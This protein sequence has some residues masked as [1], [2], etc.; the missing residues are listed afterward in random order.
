MQHDYNA[1][2]L[3]NMSAVFT[4]SYAAIGLKDCDGA[5]VLLWKQMLD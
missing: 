1:K 5:R 2:L 3:A 4:E